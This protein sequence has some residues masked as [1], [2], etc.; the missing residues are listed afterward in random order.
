MAG[1]PDR[2][3]EDG[4]HVSEKANRDMLEAIE[5]I[6][7][8]DDNSSD[9]DWTPEASSPADTSDSESED[10]PLDERLEQPTKYFQDLDSLE[11]KVFE[12]SM[13]EFYTVIVLK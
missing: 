10:H 2:T 12:N 9:Q 3:T 11:S 8:F 7:V 6:D 1:I 4:L 13:F 5:N